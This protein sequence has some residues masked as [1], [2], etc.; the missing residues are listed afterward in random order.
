MIFSR[1]L[2]LRFA[3]A[4]TASFVFL[5]STPSV[6]NLAWLQGCWEGGG[7]SRFSE[8]WMR[9]EG[10]TMLAMSRTIKGTKTVSHEFMRVWTDEEG[11]IF[12]TAYPSGQPGATFT[13][14]RLS[15]EEV[16]FENPDHDFPQRIIYRKSDGGVTG[17]IE[18]TAEG[19]S[20]AID[21]PMKRTSCDEGPER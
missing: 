1:R 15:N 2:A 19:K 7:A 20:R 16:V 14:V 10:G 4:L 3:L 6:E 9:P 12:F 21:F 13:L 5:G 18:G 11:H 17:R 8:Q